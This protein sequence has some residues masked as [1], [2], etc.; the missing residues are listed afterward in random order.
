MQAERTNRVSWIGKPVR[1]FEDRRLLVAGGQYVEDVRVPGILSLAVARSPYPHARLVSLDVSAARQAPG[2]L[3][4]LTGADVKGLG[5]VEVGPFV[6]NVM[7]P[8]QPLLVLD[9]ARYTGE[10]VAAVLTD[11]SAC[12]HDAVDLID[13]EWDPLPVL[14]SVEPALASGAPLSHPEL[15]A[16]VREPIAG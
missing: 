11:D 3:D 8:H 14:S 4:V 16:N 12:A 10:P 9:V 15:G 13:V 5:N 7:K 1:R 6:P 2:V